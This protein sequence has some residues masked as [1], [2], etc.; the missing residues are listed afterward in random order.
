MKRLVWSL[1]AGFLL[2]GGSAV[3]AQDI[4]KQIVSEKRMNSEMQQQQPYVILISADGF[5]Y[6]YIDKYQAPFLK[7]MGEKGVQSKGLIPSFPSVTFPNHYSIVTGMY[8]SHHGLV[9]NSMLDVKTG[10]RYSLRNQKAI[11]DPKWYGGTPL[12]VLAEQQQMLTACYYWPGSEA[13]IQGVLPTYYY[14]YSEKEPIENRI[15]E[16]V[17]WLKLPE[18]ARPHLITFYMPEVDHAGHGFG[19]DAPETAQAVQFVD[20]SLEKLT[21]AVQATGLNV[22]FVFVSDHGMNAVD[23]DKPLSFPIKVEENEL[24]L[25]SNGTYVSVFVK[26]KEKVKTFYEKIK[27]SAWHEGMDVYLK[28]EV[29][30]HLHFNAKEDRFNRI[31][32]IVLL[33]KA[34]YLFSNSKPIPGAHGYDPS[35]VKNMNA[36]FLMWGTEVKP[37]KID[38]VENVHIYPLIAKILGLNIQDTIDGDDR[39]IRELL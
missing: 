27:D 14:K 20:Q 4:E 19:P 25:V 15:Q 34:P 21:E 3:H 12:W 9:G 39:L 28:E 32:D 8:P 17:N 37:K 1:V 16:V 6:D 26:D 33:A 22:Y 30:A 11:V 18:V 13:P 36:T 31:G 5:R 38:E 2:I 23:Q 10:D 7:V 29:P 35:V 24:D